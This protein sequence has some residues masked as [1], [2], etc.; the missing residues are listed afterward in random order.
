MRRAA[1]SSFP[2]RQ[3]GA[4]LNGSAATNRGLTQQAILRRSLCTTCLAS[5]HITS[6]RRFRPSP[7]I[8][9]QQTRNGGQR[10]TASAVA[11]ATEGNRGEEPESPKEFGGAREANEKAAAKDDHGPIQE[12]D[13]RVDNGILRN[14][15]HQRGKFAL[16]VADIGGWGVSHADD[17]QVSSRASST[18]TTSWSTT[19]RPK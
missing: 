9:T 13:R 15:E 14:D 6:A 19:M 3:V 4:S 7:S 2:L 17:G 1:A 8:L 5:R 18:S 10:R 12:Y 16:P 11:T